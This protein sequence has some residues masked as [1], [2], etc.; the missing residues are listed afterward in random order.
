MCYITTSGFL[1]GCVILLYVNHLWHSVEC[2]GHRIIWKQISQILLCTFIF[3]NQLLNQLISGVITNTLNFNET[4]KVHRFTFY[5]LP[6]FISRYTY[7][8]N[9]SLNYIIII[10]CKFL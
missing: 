9:L 5:S 1:I 10:F 7:S 8:M 3:L 2:Q 6:H 4:L